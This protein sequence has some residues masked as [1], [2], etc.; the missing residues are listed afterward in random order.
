MKDNIKVA[1]TLN[2]IQI[3]VIDLINTKGLSKITV[4]D[5][6]SAAKI[7]RG[8]FYL[9]FKDKFDLIDQ[10][11]ANILEK[12]TETFKKY[13]P[14]LPRSE[15]EIEQLSLEALTYLNSERRLLRALLSENGDPVFTNK[16]K[17][18]LQ[19]VLRETLIKQ[20]ELMVKKSAIPAKYAQ[21]MALDSIVG[22]VIFWI[23]EDEPDS[24]KE[25]AQIIT[26]TRFMAPVDLLGLAINSKR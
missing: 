22:L 20:K 11:E 6:T 2:Q 23:L 18:M 24:V 4:R 14:L 9:H 3:A 7:N 10:Y 13:T 15:S 17:H 5:I 19:Y 26:R 8:T 21:E 1:R 25:V 16:I 12:L